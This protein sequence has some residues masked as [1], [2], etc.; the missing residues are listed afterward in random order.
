MFR[1]K[2]DYDRGFNTFALALYKTNSTGLVESFMSNHVHFLIQSE[3]PDDFMA[4]FRMP[5]AKYFNNKYER[6]GKLG[7][8]KHFTLEIKGL[9]HHLAAIS[10]ILRNPLHH[11]VAPIPYAY[12]Y[13]SANVIFQKEMGKSSTSD[14][15]QSKSFY[16]HIGRRVTFPESYKMSKSGLFLRESVLDIPQVENIFMTPRTFDYYMSRRTSEDWINE[17]N[18]DG[19]NSPPVTLDVIESQ[20]YMSKSKQMLV[21]EGGR[22]DYKRISDI[23][24]CTEI[25]R[26]VQDVYFKR[27][28]YLLSPSEKKELRGLMQQQYYPSGEQLNRCLAMDYQ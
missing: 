20:T 13:S 12:P 15:L 9:H 6:T 14:L 10:Y 4:T 22:L 5:Y 16:R 24:L 18:K 7:E 3:F 25:D 19:N 26:I 1:D 23:E 21:N 8:V 11:G 17:Q 2:E 28:V 27:S